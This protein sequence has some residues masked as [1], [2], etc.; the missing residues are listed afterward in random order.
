MQ[1][2]STIFELHSNFTFSGNKNITEHVLPSH[3]SLHETIEIT[4]GITEIFETGFYLFTNYTPGYG[5]KFVGWHIRPRIMIPEKWKWP[6]GVSLSTEFGYQ[7]REYSEHTWNVEIRPI[8]DKQAGN[9]YFSLNPTFGIG[10]K[11]DTASH[12]PAFEPNFKAAYTINKFA[13]GFEYY[14]DLG[15][16]DNIPG[17][18]EQEHTLFLVADFYFDPRWEINVGPGFGL[19]NN[20]DDFIFKLL[21]G[22]RINWKN[23]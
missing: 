3:H 22:R 1:K 12:T 20:G 21:I 6:V 7:R 10:I 8:V 11:P 2:G 4:H 16:V 23:K 17:S 14:G 19:T 15:E 5:Y 13:L 18:Q 9:F